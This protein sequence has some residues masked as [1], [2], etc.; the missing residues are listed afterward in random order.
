MNDIINLLPETI[1]NQIA[2]GE[3]VQRPSSV[4]KELLEN[5]VDAGATMITLLVKEGGSLLIQVVDNGSGMSHTDARMCWE[6]HATSKIRKADDLYCIKT[7][8]FRGEALASIASVARV[9]MDTKIKE[10]DTGTRIVIEGGH[11]KKHEFTAAPN[12]TN[13]SVKNLFFNIPARRNF[14]KSQTV[15]TRHIIEEFTRQVVAHPDIAFKL[16][17][18]DKEVFDLPS[19]DNK[20]RIVSVLGKMKHADLLSLNED[21]DLL[22]VSG[23]VGKPELA[24]KIRGE[25][26]LY[27]NHR[28]IKSA[29]LHHA[30][31][32]A[33]DNLIPSDSQPTYVIFLQIDPSRIDINVSP[34]KTEIKFEDERVLYSIVHAA[35]KKALGSFMLVPTL[36]LPIS[37]SPIN[38]TSFTSYNPDPK[39]NPRYNPF[40][41]E[42]APPKKQ[43]YGWEKIYQPLQNEFETQ[44]K[45]LPTHDL[46]R[47]IST[48]S[49]IDSV[50]QFEDTLVVK[51]HGELYIINILLA[52]ERIWY[53]RYL[54]SINQHQ[55]TTQQLLFPKTLEFSTADAELLLSVID[56]VKFIGFD[57]G[58]FGKNTFIING[59]PADL[60]KGNEQQMIE[61]LL[62]NLKENRTKYKL[63]EK[64]NVA[65]SM[66]K[67]AVMFAN[68]ILN[69]NEQSLLASEL[70]ACEFPRYCPF[71]RQVYVN[72]PRE[73]LNK[74]FKI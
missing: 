59:L 40:Q 23:F 74:L 43:P 9:E 13:I 63:T 15:E 57:I 27:V 24:K 34:S 6:R 18:N 44:V 37:Q 38:N 60:P 19:A 8:G 17:N 54:T 22:K 25:Q 49:L 69:P 47:T 12:G 32:S 21:T 39:I 53:E 61:G 14:L 56:E 50:F 7:F 58:E 72:L 66:A 67:N 36:E 28:Y 16:F 3:V 41:G 20:S 65:R 35:V 26:Y 51:A 31:R 4:V 48:A 42:Q 29:Y 33:Y 52:R 30:I 11:I 2:A 68:K 46:F 1:A 5:A 10:N 73:E 71:G 62:E 70:F 45:P 55:S 64:E